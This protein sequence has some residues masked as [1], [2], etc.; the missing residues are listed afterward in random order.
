MPHLRHRGQR[1]SQPVRPAAQQL[2]RHGIQSLCWA[3]L[4]ETAA[5]LYRHGERELPVLQL[6]H[7]ALCWSRRVEVATPL[8]QHGRREPPKLRLK[9]SA[10]RLA[11]RV[12]LG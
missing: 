3:P 6:F 7:V 8:Y 10:P 2:F 5:Q 1:R 4:V 11:V 12:P 9:Q